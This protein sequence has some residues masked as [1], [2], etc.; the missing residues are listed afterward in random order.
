MLPLAAQDSV[1]LRAWA[2]TALVPCLPI[3]FGAGTGSKVMRGI[4]APTLGDMITAPMLSMPILPSAY[5]PPHRR[6]P[7]R[8]SAE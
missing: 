2:E 5:L 3:M 6:E 8:L 7:R 4:A 1:R